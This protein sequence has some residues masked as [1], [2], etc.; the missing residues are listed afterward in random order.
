MWRKYKVETTDGCM[1]LDDVFRP[2]DTNVK[3]RSVL[4]NTQCG[5]MLPYTTHIDDA[6][7]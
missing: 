6:M 3:S 7:G 5:Q 2:E 4:H 1:K